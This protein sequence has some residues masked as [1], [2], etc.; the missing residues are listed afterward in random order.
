[1]AVAL[2]ARSKAAIVWPRTTKITRRGGRSLVRW[3]T[4]SSTA[5]RADGSSGLPKTPVPSDGAAT[6]AAPT[7]AARA[8]AA[9]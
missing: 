5:M 4:T 6:L 3:R 2:S 9:A 1:L 7:S 8:K